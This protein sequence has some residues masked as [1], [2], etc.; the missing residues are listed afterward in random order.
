MELTQEQKRI[1][2]S[3]EDLVINAVAG[4]GKTT[5]ILEYARRR[6]NKRILYLVF[7]KSAKQ[8]AQQLFMVN[9]LTHVSVET[10]HSLAYRFIIPGSAYRIRA[11]YRPAE[12]VLLLNIPTDRPEMLHLKIA[13]HVLEY[14][15][16]FC[17]QTASAVVDIATL[18]ANSHFLSGVRL[19]SSI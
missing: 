18:I 14:Y 3:E 19:I 6:T 11:G 15:H 16:L 12:L 17:S 13:H 9:H 1:I 10:A 8:K 5:T 2:A 4:S 7:N